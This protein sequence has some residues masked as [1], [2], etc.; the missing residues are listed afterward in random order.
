MTVNTMDVSA[1]HAM[2]VLRA[3][4]A[5]QRA[6]ALTASWMLHGRPGVG[7]TE[8]VRQLAAEQDA[9]LYDLRLTTIESQDLRGLP[10]YDHETK[11]TL[12][13]RPEDLP[14]DPAHPSLLFLDELTAAPPHL[15]PA[16]YGLLLERRVG[17]HH[18]P[19][20]VFLVAA[21]NMIE[22][23]AV[24]YEMGSALSDRL[25]HLHVRATAS[26]WLE[27]YAIPAGIHPAVLAFIRM[28]PD[29]LE[30]TSE[31]LDRGLMIA[32]T[33]RSWERVSRIMRAV[34]DRALRRVMVAGT[35]GEAISAEFMLV[36]D[37]IETSV[38][39]ER[40]LTAAPHER[41]NLYPDSMHGLHALIY[42]LVGA[43]GPQT[44]VPVID[45][46]AGIRTLDRHRTDCAYE[47]MPLAELCTHGFEMAIRRGLEQGLAQDFI[48]HP[49]YAAYAR[50]RKA[51]GL[52]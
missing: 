26:D 50:E 7:K 15:H 21:G 1:G 35:V 47:K 48:S 5:A 12:W 38:S 37:D 18:L 29:L 22:D 41:I 23:G 32:T 19:D 36:A 46:M 17:P 51:M 9:R 30:T 44:A 52:E 49:A 20:T 11:K 42:G 24:A 39:V 2:R 6:G 8:I 14:D 31:A 4:W 43:L 45:V 40:L 34:P 3:G 27:N 16:V 13:Y 33:P 25:I 10:Y 28:R